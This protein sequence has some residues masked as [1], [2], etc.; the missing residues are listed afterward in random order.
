MTRLNSMNSSPKKENR[1]SSFLIPIYEKKRT[2]VREPSA[3]DLPMR[4]ESSR[5]CSM[6]MCSKYYPWIR[7]QAYFPQLAAG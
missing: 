5:I 3:L 4:R 1:S 2:L 6:D 7:E